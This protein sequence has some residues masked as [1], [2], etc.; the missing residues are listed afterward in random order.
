MIIAIEPTRSTIKRMEEEWTNYFDT[1]EEIAKLRQGIMYP[2]D[3]HPDENM[4]GGS[5]S[6]RDITDPTA[7]MAGR[8]FANKQL[9]HLTEIVEAIEKVYNALPNEYKELVRVRYWRHNNKLTWDGVAMKIY[10]SRRQ[11]LYWRDEIMQATI[12]ILGWR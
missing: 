9:N 4:G 12:E 11:A 2:Y 6:V 7:S 10:T 5:N 3:K 1:L 8:L